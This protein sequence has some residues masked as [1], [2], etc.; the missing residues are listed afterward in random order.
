MKI[1]FAE[2]CRMLVVPYTKE[3]KIRSCDCGKSHVWWENSL[4]GKLVLYSEDHN[5]I[6][7]I[8][9]HNGL[10]T[11]DMGRHY[12]VLKDDMK[13]IIDK[14]S[15]GFLFKTYESLV[16]RVKPAMMS[17]MRWASIEEFD[18]LMDK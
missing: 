11:H 8:G 5:N 18:K 13:S 2:C 14:T 4:S 15:E 1:M 17:D 7:V 3:S 9:L 6:T 10:L 16:I 12:A